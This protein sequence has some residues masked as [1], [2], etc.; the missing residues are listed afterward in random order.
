M[1]ADRLISIIMLL[2]T[3]ERMTAEDLSEELEVS[4]RTIYRDITALSTAGIPIYTDRGPGGGIALL[5]SYRTTL[6]GIN[7][8]EAQALFMMSIPQALIE[9]GVGQ[10]L[11]SA[12]L[13]L[14]AAMP[15][16][17]KSIHFNTQ[18]RIYL[19]SKPWQAIT[20]TAPHISTLHEAIR[21]DRRIRLVFRGSFDAE[22]KLELDPL[23]LVAKMN[24]WYLVGKLNTHQR[25]LKVND[26]LDVEILPENFS[27]GEDF[28]LIGFWEQWCVEALNQRAQ[29][30]V[31]L[32]MTPG[33][34]SKLK[35]YL[36]ESISYHIPEDRCAD[37]DGLIEVFIIYDNFFQARESILGFGRAAEVLE[38]EALRLSVIDFAQQIVDY[39]QDASLD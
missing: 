26:I 2:Q 9:L 39:Y 19:D 7:E 17:Q 34:V 18:Q 15:S 21:Q 3:H 28:D 27:R 31:C 25:V 38:P 33:L 22:I 8:D 37:Q 1:R 14:A 13:K 5:D 10:K 23:G 4:T 11:K 24:T 6:T 32:K 35:F 30:K 29:Y 16:S 12:L 20:G 36:N